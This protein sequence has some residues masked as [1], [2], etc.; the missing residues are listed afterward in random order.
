MIWSALKYFPINSVHLEL[1]I[2]FWQWKSALISDYR[3]ISDI[4][5]FN[6]F[7]GLPGNLGYLGRKGEIGEWGPVGL[8][9]LQGAQ[10][11]TVSKYYWYLISQNNKLTFVW[12]S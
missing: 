10:G 5:I 9:G 12:N 6:S 2:Y 3:I 11:I 7:K 4:F 1:K 8:D